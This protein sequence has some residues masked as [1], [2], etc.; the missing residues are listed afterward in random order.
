MSIP[1]IG[2]IIKAVEKKKDRIG[3][4]L[5]NLAN[6]QAQI[7]QG[8]GGGGAGFTPVTSQQTQPLQTNFTSG[9]SNQNLANIFKPQ[10]PD[11]TQPQNYGAIGQAITQQAPSANNRLFDYLMMR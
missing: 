11:A 6:S 1:I 2:Q 10:E 8:F 4:S 3:Q 5:S 7:A 9:L